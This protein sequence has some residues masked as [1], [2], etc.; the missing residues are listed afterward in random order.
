[1]ILDTVQCT[2]GLIDMLTNHYTMTK[3]LIYV[4]IDTFVFFTVYQHFLKIFFDWDI[5]FVNKA[6]NTFLRITMIFSK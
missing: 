2:N 1:M 3:N 5:F 4:M 6:I